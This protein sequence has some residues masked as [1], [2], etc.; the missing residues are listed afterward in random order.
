MTKNFEESEEISKL[1]SSLAPNG[2]CWHSSLLGAA[3]GIAGPSYFGTLFSN[4]MLR[5]LL[6]QGRTIQEAYAYLSQYNLSFPV[7]ANLLADVC[8]ALACGWISAAYGRGA[9]IA[10]GI[11]AG[12]L[13]TSFPIIM[14]INPTSGEMPIMFRAASL[15]IPLLGSILGA[16]AYKWK[17]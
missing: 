2:F 6:G 11:V 10:Q 9:S 16:Y 12:L 5:V 1:Q 13:C 4:V 14:L 17:T 15:A 3:V 8:F 7:I